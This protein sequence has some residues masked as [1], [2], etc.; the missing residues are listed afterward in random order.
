MTT[1][2][3]PPMDED[4]WPSLGGQVIAFIE[5]GLV[6]GPGD[7]RGLPAKVD[8]E[9]RALIMRAYEVHPQFLK[10]AR[11]G[12]PLI[13]TKD[14]NP[15]AGRRRFQ[16][17]VLSLRKGKAKTEMAAWIAACE[18]HAAGPVRCDGWREGQP[19]GRGVIDPYIP[20]VAYT[21]EQTEDLA[22]AALHT[23]LSE[24]PL[25]NDFDIGL[26]RIMRING[27]GKAVALASSPDARDGARTTFEHFD[28]THRFTLPR[29]KKAHQTMLANL[30][31]RQLA[32]AWALETTT[33]FATGEG[34]VAEEAMTYARALADGTATNQRMF[35]FHRQASNDL[36]FDK[37]DELRRGMV[38]A[39]GGD[40]PWLNIDTICA[41]FD[42]PTADRLLLER[43]WGNRPVS[44]GGRAFPAK[45][46]AELARPRY[47][48]P[49][50]ELIVLG[51]DGARFHDATALIGTH[52][53][54]GF[55][56]VLGLWEP[57]LRTAAKSAEAAAWEVPQVE[58]DAT[59][60]EAFERWNV[61]RM[62]ADPYF[63]E[64]WI[65]AWQGR[66]GERR[67]IE[68]PTNRISKMAY[69]LRAY[70]TAQLEGTISHDG[71]PVFA[72]HIANAVRQA[73]NFTDEAGEKMWL[74]RKERTDSPFHMDAAMAGCLSHEARM[75]AI[76]AGALNEEDGI[77]VYIPGG[78]DAT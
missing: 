41:Q 27:D 38:E 65:A 12:R 72:R 26:E 50:G 51:F 17:V 3:V 19:V 44:G 36:D 8:N 6:F 62:Y 7:L 76:A 57:P 54:T 49:D 43:L 33:A 1:L 11:T 66:W 78:E 75:D 16:R 73:T 71:N 24:G 64:S 60:T 23:I 61:W 30:P 55:Q 39:S 56:W 32:D 21:E 35:Y 4:L 14:S 45:R 29:L 53:E 31:K 58:V 40:A 15:L 70:H 67:V 9:K 37:P 69:A 10:S 22:Y 46:W 63:W 13:K 52:V 48:V 5:Q 47:Q 18:L 42:D 77:S 34:S 28:E 25:A 68:W 2:V 20:M 74:I 59:V